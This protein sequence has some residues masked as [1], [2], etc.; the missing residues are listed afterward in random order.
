[1]SHTSTDA[2]TA[3]LRA[4]AASPAISTVPSNS[5]GD[6]DAGRDRDTSTLASS[7]GRPRTPRSPRTPRHETD[8]GVRLLGGPEFV[9]E[10]ENA[11]GGQVVVAVAEQEGGNSGESGLPPPYSVV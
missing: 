8:A 7:V 4:H 10:G 3:H 9:R 6:R 1:M 11:S 5:S 2:S